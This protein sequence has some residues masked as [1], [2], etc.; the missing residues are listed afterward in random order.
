MEINN[1]FEQ[2]FYRP[3][4]IKKAHNRARPKRRNLLISFLD[5]V[6]TA[7]S[8]FLMRIV[9]GGRNNPCID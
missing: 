2:D 6:R 9:H 8:F 3:V 5:P 7:M 1:K 4:Q